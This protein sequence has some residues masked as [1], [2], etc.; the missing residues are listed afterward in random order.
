M[1]TSKETRLEF[2]KYLTGNLN[3]S[4]FSKMTFDQ[5]QE[6]IINLFTRLN[7]LRNSGMLRREIEDLINQIYRKESDF[8]DNDVLFERRF[9]SLTEEI[10]EF[11]PD[12]F[13]W[14]T[15]F[16]IYMKKWEKAFKIDW[17]KDPSFTG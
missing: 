9:T 16:D 6:F 5:Y 10:L 14:S 4:T 12:P 8:F 15:D 11:C 7:E 3:Y 17:F 2:E 13:F 1:A